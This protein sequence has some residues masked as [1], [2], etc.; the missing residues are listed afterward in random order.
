MTEAPRL[1]IL[2]SYPCV[3]P[4]HGGQIRLAEI[5]AGYQRAGYQVQSLNFYPFSGHGARGPHDFYY[6]PDSPWRQWQGKSV[7]LI[8][9]YTSGLCAAGD[10]AL[11]AR[12]TAAVAGEPVVIHV[13][14]PWLLPLVERWRQEGRFARAVLVYGSQNIEA[15]LKR[16]IL[17]QYGVSEAA[18]VTAAIDAL[19]RRACQ[20]ADVVF[21]VS[22][23]DRER[24]AGYGDA[25]VV[26]AANGISAWQATPAALQHWRTRLPAVPFPL[27]VGSAH[28]PNISG[29]FEAI[30]DVLGFLAPDN[31]LCV[32]GSVSDHI[33]SHPRFQ[34]WG[35]L[36]HSRIQALGL[37]DD[38]ALAAIKTLAHVFVLP[39][40]AGG[41]SNIKTAEALYSGRYV[42]GTPTSFR[43][44]E[45]WLDLPGVYCA[46]P[47][48]DFVR[49]IQRLLAT[50]ALEPDPQAVA[51]RRHLLWS[52]TLASIPATL[53]R[54]LAHSS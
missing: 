32:V 46:E 33:V 47:G 22:E 39:I 7:P 28:P 5:I 38:D 13:E 54:F 6:P 37:V 27:F 23:A 42:V 20:V 29:F 31:R 48:V 19:E 41:G 12:L 24:L 30:G 15:P 16:A 3:E 14:Q 45:D 25:D 51:R 50:P 1:L 10:E 9:D 4:R 21:A 11:Y 18:E 36:N 49:T 17:D 8:D 26:L 34:T 40:T 35:P 44:F 53:K 43:G 52:H 2:G